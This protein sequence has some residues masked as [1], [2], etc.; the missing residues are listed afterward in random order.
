[1]PGLSSGALS[2]ALLFTSEEGEHASR[3]LGLPLWIW[4]ILN[5][6]LFLAVLVYFVAKPMA[7][8]FRK[9]QLEIEERRLQAEKQRG[10]VQRLSAEIRERTAKLEREIEQIRVQAVT[11]GKSARAE[12]SA[13]ADEEAARAGKD[14]QEEIARRL[15]E[16]KTELRR[17]AAALTAER[18]TEILSREIT[19]EDRRRLLDDGVNRLKQAP[20]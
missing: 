7:A 12:L 4:Q 15:A 13:R 8:A 5:L 1:L 9:R 2:A 14:A 16:A 20:R 18:S 3:F 19:D 17:T 10:Q 6:G 11:D